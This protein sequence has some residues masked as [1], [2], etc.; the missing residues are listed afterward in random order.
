MEVL[1]MRTRSRDKNGTAAT[2]PIDAT[3]TSGCS[4]TVSA[5]K[6]DG[7]EDVQEQITCTNLSGQRRKKAR[8]TTSTFTEL[9]SLN[10]KK[11][12]TTPIKRKS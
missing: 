4:A 12:V 11:C 9:I 1:I 10:Q 2:N 5:C 3:S 6:T 8:P 7:I